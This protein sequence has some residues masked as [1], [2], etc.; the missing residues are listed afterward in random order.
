MFQIKNLNTVFFLFFRGK[1]T[2]EPNGVPQCLR[3]LYLLHF[4][5]ISEVDIA[6]G[7]VRPE[8]V[9]NENIQRIGFQN[10]KL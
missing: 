4:Y 8:I 7:F 1:G 5:I 3:F 9:L 10:W 6:K 2:A